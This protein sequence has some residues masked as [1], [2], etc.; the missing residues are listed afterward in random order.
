MLP[1]GVTVT[2]TTSRGNSNLIGAMVTKEC[3]VTKNQCI[4]CDTYPLHARYLALTKVIK[5]PLKLGG[6]RLEVRGPT[7][8][9]KQAIYLQ[10]I[11]YYLLEYIYKCTMPSYPINKGQLNNY[12][13]IPPT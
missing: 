11:G 12:N 8:Q 3:N 4:S 5:Q 10:R 7:T 2:Y 13:F 9:L 6:D 1:M